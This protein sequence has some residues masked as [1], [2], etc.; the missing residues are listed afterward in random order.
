MPFLFAHRYLTG[1]LVLASYNLDVSQLRVV[2][3]GG[4]I[5]TGISGVGIIGVEL[6]SPVWNVGPTVQSEGPKK[7]Q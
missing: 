2:A 1:E 4:Q 3:K 6:T 7:G 5:G